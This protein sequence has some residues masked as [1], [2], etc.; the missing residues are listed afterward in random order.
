M[1][2]QDAEL[3]RE[4]DAANR[5]PFVCTLTGFQDEK[6]AELIAAIERLGGTVRMKE[7]FD[8]LT[9]HVIRPNDDTAR[10]KVLAG[11]LLHSWIVS[12]EWIKV[13]LFCPRV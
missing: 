3:A 11:Q 9:T 8:K 6:S 10:L 2:Q 7:P 1:E 12:A 4:A 5:T 13:K